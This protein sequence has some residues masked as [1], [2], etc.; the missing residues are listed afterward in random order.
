MKEQFTE[1]TTPT[2]HQAD[3]DTE[4]CTFKQETGT[5]PYRLKFLVQ[6]TKEELAPRYYAPLQALGGIGAVAY[7]LQLLLNSRIHSVF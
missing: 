6:R 7:E 5:Q 2:K 4:K 3:S 1:G